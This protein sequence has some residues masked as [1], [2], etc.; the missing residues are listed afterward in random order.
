MKA[1][2]SWAPPTSCPGP[3]RRRIGRGRGRGGLTGLGPLSTPNCPNFSRRFW[4]QVHVTP[5]YQK[6]LDR[7]VVGLDQR[8]ELAGGGGEVGI[9]LAVATAGARAGDRGAAQGLG[10]L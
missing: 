2:P 7:Q 10:G 9:D 4:S 8:V 1:P 3:K 6:A 5:A